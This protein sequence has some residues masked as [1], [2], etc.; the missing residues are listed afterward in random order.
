MSAPWTLYVPV[1]RSVT[2]P[3]PVRVLEA[4][5][6]TLSAGTLPSGWPS[7]RTLRLP[8]RGS[9]AKLMFDTLVRPRCTVRMDGWMLAG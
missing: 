1:G 5:P 3:E 9:R 8:K 7:T 6:L 2:M 4:G